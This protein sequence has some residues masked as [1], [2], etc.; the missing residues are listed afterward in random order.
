MLGTGSP[1][2]GEFREILED[3][4]FDDQRAGD[5]ISKLRQLMKKDQFQ[6]EPIELNKVVL[7]VSTLLE[8]DALIREMTIERDLTRISRSCW[9]TAFSCSRSC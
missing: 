7:D 3:I 9:A 5:I 1:D 4:A 2:P 6:L 8:S